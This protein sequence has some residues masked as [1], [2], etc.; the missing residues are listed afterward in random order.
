M[1]ATSHNTAAFQQS[2]S[3][4]GPDPAGLFD[5]VVHHCTD[6]AA[7]EV[8]CNHAEGSFPLL[9]ALFAGQKHAKKRQQPSWPALKKY[10]MTMLPFDKQVESLAGA[11]LAHATEA[12][13]LEGLRTA[14]SGLPDGSPVMLGTVSRWSQ[15]LRETR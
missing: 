6:S 15:S 12:G 1:S 9:V 8:L 4:L 14:R 13:L 5:L 11:Q 3:G 2:L 10:L 7:A